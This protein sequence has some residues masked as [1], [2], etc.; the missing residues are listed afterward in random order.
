[1]KKIIII[2][3]AVLSIIIIGIAIT[4]RVITPE[5]NPTSNVTFRFSQNDISVKLFKNLPDNQSS[6]ITT[7]E[8]TTTLVLDNGSYY[9]IPSGIKL[10]GGAVN[11][12]ITNDTQFVV[13]PTYSREVLN[14]ELNLQQTTIH[15]TIKQTY[16]LIDQ[17]YT[18]QQGKLYNHGQW[19][20]TTLTDKRATNRNPF[21]T[22]R[23]VALNENGTWQTVTKPELVLSA[24]DYPG[25]PKN[26][27]TAINAA[28]TDTMTN[29]T[30]IDY[31]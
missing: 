13:D 1:M 2:S 14:T 16:S 30:F 8:E 10:A 18:I 29:T 19:Y 20:I 23:I 25:I 6:E 31:E 24:I 22:Y 4:I 3:A 7:M 26:I 5:Q 12:D 15:N 9:Y 17:N 11:F 21:D 28:T 27:L